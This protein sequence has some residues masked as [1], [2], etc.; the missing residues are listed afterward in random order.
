[1]VILLHGFEGQNDADTKHFVL[2]TE[3]YRTT[4]KRSAARVIA[5]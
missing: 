4:V 5:V 3:F 2:A 1:M